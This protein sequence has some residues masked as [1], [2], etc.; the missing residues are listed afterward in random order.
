[1]NQQQIESIRNTLERL[2]R[3]P[4]V[5]LL[6]PVFLAAF[7]L[8]YY[9]LYANAGLN[10]GGEGGT[11]GVVAM[12]LMAGQRPIVDTFLGY[13]VMWFFP[14]AGL[15]EL[16]GPD[17]LALRWYFFAFCTVSG[18][19]TYF[20]VCGY[21]RN[22]WYSAVPAALVILV[23]GM[24]FRNYMP[25]LGVLNALFLTRAF[26]M[27]RESRRKT[28]AW[29]LAAGAGLGLTF[30]F[31]IDIGIF[32]MLIFSGLAIL[33]P[34]GERGR[35]FRRGQLALAG[36]AGGFLLTFAVH[37]PVWNDAK[38]RG[39]DR[40]FFEQYTAWLGM[41]GGEFRQ[42]MADLE[43]NHTPAQSPPPAQP[44]QPAP[45]DQNA[46]PAQPAQVASAAPAAAKPEE[47]PHSNSWENRGALSRPPLSD[48]LR[49]KN[50][51]ARSFVLSA[52]LP[53]LISAVAIL[54]GSIGLLGALVR[55]DP[56]AK[57]RALY[58]LAVLGCALALL[59][60]FLFFRPDTP[61]LSEMMVPF[62]TALALFVWASARCALRAK[63]PLARV[64]SWSFAALCLASAAIY[65]SHA[66]PKESSGSIAAK[67]KA[68]HEFRALNGVRVN[69]SDRDAAWLPGLRDAVLRHSSPGEY[70]LCLPYSP[71]INFMTDRPSPLYNLYVDN[72]TAGQE[73]GKFFLK[74]MAETPPP[75][76]VI[77][78]RAINRSE[79][80][81]F[82]NWAPEPYRWLRK[83]YVFFGRYFRSEVFVRK[84]KAPGP[85]TP[86]AIEVS[87]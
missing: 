45:T 44:A 66:F 54:A 22:A 33:Y 75:V 42:Q 82:R 8:F 43:K 47:K 5:R 21:T 64:A 16:T 77:D 73:F 4:R 35:F 3:S 51:A 23:P 38:A 87:D 53:L 86:E 25:F 78:Q 63:R 11:A 59:P 55:C 57:E 28:L 30:L 85:V 27:R 6:M 46:P 1:M 61:H 39:Y 69:V 37:L 74:L 56:E 10:L 50:W 14:V 36:A 34:F 81:R 83:N 58:P 40:A 79:Y 41:I 7:A 19:L 26:V 12:R 84:D 70:V 62:L 13:N 52:Y 32:C 9:S 76:I 68:A 65:F 17:Y 49:G 29:M 31:R 15:F 80:S 60:Q 24:I 67:K 20:I 48:A 2:V 71:T 18:L 72:S